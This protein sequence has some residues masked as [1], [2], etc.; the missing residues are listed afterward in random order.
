[1]KIVSGNSAVVQLGTLETS[2]LVSA[3]GSEGVDTFVDG[4]AS[5]SAA[6]VVSAVAAVRPVTRGQQQATLE[7]I[8]SKVSQLAAVGRRGV[9][10]VDLDLT[11]L[12]PRERVLACLRNIGRQHPE[13]VEFQQP[14]NL[15]LIP[16]YTEGAIEG[17][18][19]Q[20]GLQ[21]KYPDLPL[22]DIIVAGLRQ[23][24]WSSAPWETDELN[25]GLKDF[26][27]RVRAAG[28]EV[29][30]VSNRP[31]GETAR[32]RSLTTL[33]DA[34][35]ENP[36]IPLSP[37]GG[38]A[39]AKRQ[40]QTLIRE[41]YGEPVAVIDDRI[42]NRNAVLEGNPGADVLSVAIAAPGLSWTDDVEGSRWKISSF[43]FLPNLFSEKEIA[44]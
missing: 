3:P 2:A 20:S 37:G 19:R 38:D 43:E 8:L 26:M 32:Q 29:I 31:G 4:A 27:R 25:A 41:Q 12:L 44:S 39:E 28:G 35:V 6:Q 42:N 16:G 40:L 36:I 22:Y 15:P 7:A 5:S 18:V 11:A 21:A 23:P 14:E 17:F 13:I 9:V 33:R 30:F 24:Y 1:M 34:G 10:E